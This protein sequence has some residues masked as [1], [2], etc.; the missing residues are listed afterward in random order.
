MGDGMDLLPMAITDSVATLDLR[1][2]ESRVLAC[3]VALV[4]QF[5][6]VVKVCSM[7]LGDFDF[8]VA[9]KVMLCYWYDNDGSGIL[10]CRGS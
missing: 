4:D 3:W 1:L 2:C 7:V 9:G 10:V 6:V 8:K 5:K